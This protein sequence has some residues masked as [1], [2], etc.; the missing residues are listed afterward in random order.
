M[1]IGIGHDLVELERVRRI[2]DGQTAERFLEKM[3]TPAERQLLSGKGMRSAEYTA[4]RFAA[5]EAVVKAL[6]CGIGGT[7]GLLDIEVLPDASGRPVCSLTGEA[8]QR[9]GLSPDEVKLH[10]SITH[11]RSLAS[12]YAVAERIAGYAGEPVC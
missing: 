9:L 11:E 7:V 12:A 4:G 2:L 8:W 5:K 6:G 3:L 1:I 10:V